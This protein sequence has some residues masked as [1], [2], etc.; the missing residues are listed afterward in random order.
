M[1]HGHV[2]VGVPEQL[3]YNLPDECLCCITLASVFS[4]PIDCHLQLK[5]NILILIKNLQ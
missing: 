3:T 4:F 2:I 1:L 5:E